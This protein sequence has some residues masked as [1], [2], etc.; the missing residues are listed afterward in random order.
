MD[1]VRYFNPDDI[2]VPKGYQIEVY[3]TGLDAPIGMVF[4]RNGDLIIAESGYFSGKP[5]I[6]RLHMGEF[7]IIAEDFD[8]PLT[9]I[10]EINGRLYVSNGCHISVVDWD[11]IKYNIISGLPCM[12]D[13]GC[14]KV[15]LGNDGKI[16]WGQGTATNS[17]V[18][19]PDNKWVNRCAHFCD[20]PGTYVILNGQNFESRNMLILEEEPTLTGA[21][22]P[23][24]VPNQ[25]YEV[26]KSNVKAN[27]SIL[28]AN[29]DGTDIEMVAWGLRFPAGI[30][31]DN[32]YR[33]FVT[34]QG[35]DD[36]GSRPIVNA[37]DEFLL[38][39]PNLWYGW[40]DFAGGEP[41]TLSRFRPEGGKQPEFLLTN[42]P[43]IPRPPFALLPPHCAVMGFDFNYNSN[44]NYYGDAFIAEHGDIIVTTDGTPTPYAGFGHRVS[45]LDMSS[46]LVTTF[47][48]N[49]SGY[50]SSI[51]REGGFGHPVDICFG[52]EGAMYILDTGLYQ[53]YPPFDYLPNTGAV[54][55]VTRT[56]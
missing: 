44:F 30:H 17:G 4:D 10:N 32:N 19:G 33:L 52:P 31:F 47:A 2:N 45:K 48:I 9:G 16:Y 46:G 27:G 3:I 24:S 34:N 28:K 51:S 40:P 12:G 13:Y 39:Q 54:W 29:P 38:I 1:N 20:S 6:Y 41:V 21:F 11:G 5:R 14:S 43:S 37:P 35:Y 26:R 7:Q 8:V 25:P 53:G 23:Y 15:V 36:R 49:K 22:S 18:V 55:R 50:P 42:H 56:Q